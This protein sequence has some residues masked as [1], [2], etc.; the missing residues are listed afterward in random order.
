MARRW[1]PGRSPVAQPQAAGAQ[2][3]KWP[4][5]VVTMASGG[6]IR[7]RPSR[8]GRGA[9][10]GR[11]TAPRRR[12][13]P[14]RRPPGPPRS[15]PRRRWSE[16]MA[17]TPPPGPGGPPDEGPGVG[18]DGDRR[19]PRGTGTDWLQVDVRPARAGGR[20]G[21]PVR[22]HLVEATAEHQHGVRLEEPRQHGRR[23]EVAAH[24]EIE[25]VVVGEGIGPP[26]GSHHGQVHHLRQAHEVGRRPRAEDAGA[27]EDDGALRVEEEVEDPLDRRRVRLR[28]ARRSQHGGGRDAA[29]VGGSGL[30]EEVLGMPRGTGP[31]RPVVARRSASSRAP[32]SAA[33]SRTSRAQRQRPPSVATRSASWNASRP[34][35]DRVTWPTMAI[36]GAESACAACRAIARFDDPTAR[37]TRTAAGRPVSAPCA[38]AMKPAPLSWRVA[39]TR[40]PPPAGRPRGAGSSRPG[41]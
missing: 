38:A 27:G 33:T 11:P 29:A 12:H 20:H 8:P 23:G 21:P 28:G 10:R 36:S 4:A 30:V 1:S 9:G 2:P 25:G 7:P 14:P 34:R 41:R 15:R 16:S 18:G 37:V 13:E 24:P 6:R 26:P 17:S 3:P 22:G 40:M 31:G 32:G 19:A 39:M 35:E 5:S